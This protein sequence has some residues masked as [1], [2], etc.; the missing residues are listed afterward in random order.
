MI[1]SRTTTFKK[2]KRLH[3]VCAN[4]LVCVFWQESSWNSTAFIF[5]GHF[6]FENFPSLHAV[7]FF[8]S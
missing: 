2:T 3:V 1:D 8:H 7:R 5:F 6:S 4:N